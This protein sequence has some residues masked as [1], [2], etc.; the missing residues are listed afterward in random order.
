MIKLCMFDL[1]GTLIDS[2]P[3]LAASIN[4]A[5]DQN[6]LP[7]RQRE[8]IARNMGKGLLNLIRTA[9]PEGYYSAELLEKLKVIV[10]AH[11]SRNCT[12]E[13]VLYVGIE[14]MLKALAASGVKLAVIT[15]KPHE[16]LDKIMEELLWFADFIKVIGA[17]EYP[18]KP[19]PAAL[20]A[21][22]ERT[23]FTNDECMYIGD[24]AIDIETALNAGVRPVGVS[25]GY[26]SAEALKSAGAGFIIEKPEELYKLIR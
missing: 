19:D 10:V 11:Y 23:G 26:Q 15:N 18:N 14:G 3:D 7:P 22:M 25:W 20:Y 24:T 2:V 1:D 5:L 4:F 9:I 17:G 8:D 13:T 21:V 12:K 16:F 6:G